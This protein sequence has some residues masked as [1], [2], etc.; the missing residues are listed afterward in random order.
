MQ[1][2]VKLEILCDLANDARIT[3]FAPAL[4]Q[5]WLQILFIMDT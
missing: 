2:Y 1:E 3:L 5:L 4:Y